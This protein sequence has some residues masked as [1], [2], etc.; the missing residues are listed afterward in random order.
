[1]MRSFAVGVGEGFPVV[2]PYRIREGTLVGLDAEG[3]LVPVDR[4]VRFVGVAMEARAGDAE[5]PIGVVE[6]GSFVFRFLGWAPSF[7][8]KGRRVWAFSES[9]VAGAPLGTAFEVGRVVGLATAGGG[10]AGVRVEICATAGDESH[11]E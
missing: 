2:G 4:A 6:S 1:M 9:E 10:S 8:D 3:R 7:A 5:R 11:S